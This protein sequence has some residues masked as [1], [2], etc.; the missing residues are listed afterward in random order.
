MREQDS[1]VSEYMK[2]NSNQMKNMEAQQKAMDFQLGQ[3]A[4]TVG[5]MQNKGKFPSTTEPNPKE[6]C[7]AIELRS[8]TK[9]QGPQLS[10]EDDDEEKTAEVEEEKEIEE[11]E[12]IEPN[13][14]DEE[15]KGLMK[16]KGKEVESSHRVPKWKIA[17]SLKEKASDDIEC[18]EWGIPKVPDR[19]PFPRRFV[20][21]KLDSSLQ[22]NQPVRGFLNR[23][24]RK[25]KMGKTQMMR[26]RFFSILLII[27][28]MC[29]TKK[30]APKVS[31]HQC[32]DKCGSVSIPYPFGIGS[33][34]S[35][36]A[37]FA[38]E[39]LSKGSNHPK[40]YLR[41][42]GGLEVVEVSVELATVTVVQ[43][44]TPLN[45]SYEK[46]TFMTLGKSLVGTPFT[47]FSSLAVVGCK[48]EVW[49]MDS[50][51]N[52]SSL[53]C[54]PIC[55]YTTLGCNG[56]NCCRISA[57][58]LGP[59]QE[60][61]YVPMVLSWEFN[62]PMAHNRQG[63]SCRNLTYGYSA[64]SDNN[65]TSSIDRRRCYCKDG[66]TGNPYKVDGDGGCQDI[67]ECLNST[68][69]NCTVGTT[70]FNMPGS[71]TCFS[72]VDQ[73]NMKSIIAGISSGAG[74]LLLLTGAGMSSK[75]I[76]KRIK[77]NRKKKFFKHNGGLLLQQQ[78]SSNDGG[79]ERIK[80]FSSKELAF[81]TDRYND[82]R[83]LGRGG[84]GT[85]YKGMLPDGRIVAV[86]KSKKMEEAYI[87][88]FIN[89]V[90]ILSQINHRNVVKLLGCCLETEVPLLVY[91]FISNGTLFEHIHDQNDEYFPL[92]WKMRVRIA[93]EV[94]S[95]LSY[96]HNAASV[97]IY[98]RDIKSTNILL[99]DKYRAKVSDFGTSRSISIDQTH[100]TTKVLGTFGYLD[101][102]YFQ[103]SQFTEKSDVYSFGV[104]MVEL[105]TGEKAISKVRAET[106]KSLATHF[107]HSM[108]ENNLSD[109]LDP[110]ILKEGRM[111]EI[112]AVAKL[113][114][115]CLN[116]TGKRRPTMKAV[117]AEL[118]GILMK[119]DAS[120]SPYNLKD[121]EF[122]SIE[123]C[124]DFDFPSTSNSTNVNVIPAESSESPLMFGN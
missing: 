116:L 19:I 14:E 33:E 123:I 119:E 80:L 73:H 95:V 110:E 93:T 57:S 63:V 51:T 35:I 10:S 122:E 102:E 8:G 117:S 27:H 45:C 76:R 94:A 4:T 103:S 66:F 29:S 65:I 59:V 113:A 121:M 91:E 71:F 49:L 101:P 105:L 75:V 54:R 48:T 78:L 34:C 30:V 114:K 83:I 2:S 22:F 61:E 107:L 68:L 43:A 89:E 111:E 109:I 41:S 24:V 82:N 55:G 50:Q 39:C 46:N 5:N 87:E 25:L 84:Q 15:E 37:S 62:D 28:S 70:C 58:T 16:K 60:L 44:V 36:N 120:A 99:D 118:V 17:K 90:V 85:V 86:K 56:I 26:L 72:H 6:Y 100:L 31:S 18:D 47:I 92:S 77:A 112:V 23:G 20:K 1:K 21:N 96:L 12:E 64:T 52:S 79:A 69:N 88:V 7:K 13:Q 74:T 32:P 98:H 81:A 11:D 3:L 67:N 42:I 9:Y 106:G 115:R 108:E 53:G 38:V 104:V 97:L 124:G 40:P